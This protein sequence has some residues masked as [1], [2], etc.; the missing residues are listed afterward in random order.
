MAIVLTDSIKALD[1]KIGV[2]IASIMN[3]RVKQ[4]KK[5]VLT[6]VE[7]L[8]PVWVRN[9]P[10]VISLLK[11]AEPFSLNAQ[12]GLPPGHASVFTDDL[13]ES[14]I[15]SIEVKITRFDKDYRGGVEFSFQPTHFRNLL[16][17][18]STDFLLGDVS[19]NWLHWLL[20]RGDSII[21]VGYHYE[22]EVGEGRSG[23]GTM[24]KGDVW[25]IPPEFSGIDGNNFVTRLFDNREKQLATILPQL[26]KA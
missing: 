15:A 26:L 22:P 2:A 6:I 10:E 1:R 25:R 3:Q 7:R 12:L 17:I 24:K 18:R 4:N 9:S 19:V 8:I 14:I 11:E 23:G 5:K 20:K 13:V 16:G 21:I